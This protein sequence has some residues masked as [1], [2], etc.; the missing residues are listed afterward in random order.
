MKSRD[1]RMESGDF[2]GA[3]PESK[4]KDLTISGRKFD[5]FIC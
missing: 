1:E 3:M 2:D 4:V 5:D